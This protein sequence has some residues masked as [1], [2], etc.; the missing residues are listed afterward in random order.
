MYVAEFI[1]DIGPDQ[2]FTLPGLF[3]PFEIHAFS[4][5]PGTSDFLVKGVREHL[6]SR[7]WTTYTNTKEG[8]QH[9]RLSLGLYG[10][11]AYLILLH[12]WSDL[13]A[14]QNHGALRAGG[15]CGWRPR[16]SSC[17]LKMNT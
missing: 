8:R 17:L 10:C 9:T 7:N 11:L 16:V 14:K 15:A 6:N 1:S 2:F 13:H 3:I 12:F 4:I 5:C